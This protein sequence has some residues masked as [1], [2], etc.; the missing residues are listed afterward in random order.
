MI[1]DPGVLLVIQGS[2][3]PESR[4]LKHVSIVSCQHPSINK[5]SPGLS[6]AMS[7]PGTELGWYRLSRNSA[8]LRSS[9]L[10]IG[11]EHEYHKDLVSSLSL[12]VSQRAEP[13]G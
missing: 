11:E 8:L 3:S 13:S 5:F 9:F 7:K 2:T 12:V 10:V 4:D 1:H 6:G